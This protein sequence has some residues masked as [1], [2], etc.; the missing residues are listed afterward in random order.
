M[1]A[2]ERAA[3]APA[4]GAAD[5]KPLKHLNTALPFFW[6]FRIGANLAMM[7]LVVV[8][9][10]CDL[11]LRVERLPFHEFLSANVHPALGEPVP[12]FTVG[13]I[14]YL[15]LHLSTGTLYECLHRRRITYVSLTPRLGCCS[16]HLSPLPRSWCASR[17]VDA[18][19]RM[20]TL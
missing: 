11:Y 3:A 5:A 17:C 1:L 10:Y 2:S 12:L 18:L 13:G 20:S 9:V 7:V 14:G 6:S 4:G 15:V 16:M 19:V 8:A